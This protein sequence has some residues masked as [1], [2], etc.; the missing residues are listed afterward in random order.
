MF[1]HN[2]LSS[3]FV[4][5]FPFEEYSLRKIKKQELEIFF[6]DR[7]RGTQ[8]APQLNGVWDYGRNLDES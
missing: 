3:F 5:V 7:P 4:L 8:N 1:L 6:A 2:F